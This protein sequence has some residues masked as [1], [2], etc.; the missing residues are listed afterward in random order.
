MNPAKNFITSKQK[1]RKRKA[2][3]HTH[4]RAQI[5]YTIVSPNTE[6]HTLKWNVVKLEHWNFEWD[7]N[8][9]DIGMQKLE[10][11]HYK[12]IQAP[13]NPWSKDVAFDG[14]NTIFVRLRI[15]NGYKWCVIQMKLPSSNRCTRMKRCGNG[16]QQKV[17]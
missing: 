10:Q 13:I 14:K 2:N 3:W 11:R 9:F 15:V 17:N 1:K 4:T 5:K 16:N 8:A 12:Y 7:R 6:I